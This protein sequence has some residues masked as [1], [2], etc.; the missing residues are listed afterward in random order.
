MFNIS[1]VEFYNQMHV[2]IKQLITKE[3]RMK[4]IKKIL[5]SFLVIVYIYAII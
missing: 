1:H 2:N 3:E 4:I 5:S